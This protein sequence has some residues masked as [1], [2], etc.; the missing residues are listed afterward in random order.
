MKI[1]EANI[2]INVQDIEKSVAF[3]TSI[4]FTA[5]KRWAANYALLTAP[6]IEIGLHQSIDTNSL[7]SSGN[8]SIG[9]IVGDYEE[10]V[11]YLKDLSID[12][13]TEEEKNGKFLYFNDPDGT[14]LYFVIHA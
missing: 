8:T 1:K 7:K 10:A 9:F 6:G 14:A 3:Y 11:T 4:G 13:H 12:F 2:T 5:K